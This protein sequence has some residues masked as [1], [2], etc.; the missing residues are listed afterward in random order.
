MERIEVVGGP[1]PERIGCLGRVVTPPAGYRTYPFD[2]RVTSEV[3][4]LL[5]D[6]PLGATEHHTSGPAWTCAIGRKDVR[7]VMAESDVWS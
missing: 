5:D 6:D 2:K 3:I 4:I 1:W 7:S